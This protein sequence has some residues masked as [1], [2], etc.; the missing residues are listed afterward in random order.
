MTSSSSKRYLHKRSLWLSGSAMALL[1]LALSASSQLPMNVA[2]ANTD[3][4]YAPTDRHRQ[5]SRLVSTVMERAHYRQTVI[6]DP[7]SSVMLD[8]YL[9]NLDP[10]RSYFLASDIKEF[11]RIRYQLD[12]AVLNGSIDPA[13]SVYNRFQTRN[14]ERI[15]YALELLKTEIDFTVDEAFDYDRSKA[16][17][18]DS[19]AAMN[20]LWRKRVKNDALSLMLTGKTW[21]E[22]SETLNKRYA[23]ALKNMERTT[24]DDIF[25]VFMNSFVH[26]FDPHSNYF[27]P[28][29]S[30][31]FKIA[32][33][34]SYEGIGASLSVVD[35]FV[36]VQNV[37][38]GGAAAISGL[39]NA[40]DRITA[41]GEGKA[42]KLVDVTG[43]RIDDV[44]QLIRGKG[45]TTVRLQILPAGATPGTT[46]K[47]IN[48]VRNKISM[49]TLA[50]KQSIRTI[51]RDGKEIKVGVIT[52][53]SFYQDT[54]AEQAGD[55]NFRSLTRD[56]R[57]LI[58]E[59]KQ[60][61]VEAIVMDLR[62][63]GGGN[64]QEAIGLTGLFISTGPVVQVRQTGGQIEALDDTDSSVA[65]D[66]PMTVLIDRYSASA[67]EIFAGAI[68]DYG[69]GLVLGQQS[70]GKGT[71][72]TVNPLDRFTTS[73]DAGFGHLTITTGKF[74]RIT[75]E[76]TQHRGVEPDVMLPSAISIEDIG[77]SS[78]DSALPWDRIH[79]ASFNPVSNLNQSVK[80][81]VNSLL[82]EHT[83]RTISDA[84]YQ[85]LLKNIAAYEELRKEKT[86][87]LNLK[88]RQQQRAQ[89][90]QARLQRANARRTSMGQAA[91]ASLVELEKQEGIE[92]QKKDATP[93]A[94]LAETAE[95]TA[96]FARGWVA[97]QH[98]VVTA[99][100]QP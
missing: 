41:V 95:I 67:S 14:R 75:G 11:E 100:K 63:D 52:V 39:I 37:I 28:R 97:N 43:W 79:A 54:D 60:A 65:W 38:A 34:L 51:K 18:L 87:S 90:D 72:Q 76:S 86:I 77:E 66:G 99:N 89:M 71:V 47:V 46:E 12:D 29:D 8:R 91:F 2:V 88:V 26:V 69:R 96:D 62:A 1:A 94:L 78:M 93:D 6:N 19:T 82:N 23:R 7:V 30:N 50:A 57:N 13:F 48:L 27:S 31:E 55:P 64:L 45:G 15:S 58:A 16:P 9:E 40:N 5:V 98:A 74:Y 32:M 35:D 4:N 85:Y 25:D 44:V 49:E 20:E 53:P 22:T 36:V 80:P 68:Q 59:L 81:T 10:A 17:W 42:G 61:G 56:V 24:S 84:D 33:S 70:F 3:S 73:K 21:T 92:A 83:Q